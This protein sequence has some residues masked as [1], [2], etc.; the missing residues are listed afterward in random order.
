LNSSSFNSTVYN[1]KKLYDY[2]L[3][4][5]ALLMP[6]VVKGFP[7]LIILAA[8]IGIAYFFRA[9]QKLGKPKKDYYILP[10]NLLKDA[11]TN[12]FRTK[13]AL[14]FMVILFFVYVASAFF[15][16][17][18]EV[19]FQKIILKSCYLYFPLIFSLT[20]WDKRKLLLV[21]DFFVLG[22]CLQVI[23]S[24]LDAFWESGFKF[25]SFE[26]T[27]VNLS[28]NLHP[29]Y[30]AFLVNIGFIFNSIRIIFLYKERKSLS[31]NR[32]RLIALVGF[33]GYIM[34][35][36]SKAG[37]LT[38]L[39]TTITLIIYS[40]IVIKSSKFT[41]LVIL[42]SIGVFSLLS[43]TF[44]SMAL[45]RY[46]TM[47]NSIEKKQEVRN[48][49]KRIGSSQI[50]LVL[51]E[52][53]WEAIKQSTY[54]GYG[55]GNGKNALQETLKMNNEKFVFG[56]NHNS[57][58]QFFEIMLSIGFVGLLLMILIL[59]R[60]SL[61]FGSFTAISILLTFTIVVNFAVE[62]MMERQTGSI[63][64]VWLLCLLTSGR[65]I[66]KTVFKF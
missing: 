29:G 9:Y 19:A 2:A 37:V 11:F 26:F 1:T 36:S 27:Y 54:L 39:V 30:A 48:K 64:I 7:V 49:S 51:W 56:L 35:L 6:L 3:A 31:G 63:P 60:S 50:R 20:K 34:L 23:V 14:L 12:I 28:F 58:N 17:N 40:L 53:S 45:T 33:L 47:K 44:G 38:I 8:T 22:C 66:F 55:L 46:N 59:I 24:L 4:F 5:M 61:G 13:G 43:Y 16:D 65:S 62:S 21:I 42:L 57:H 41:V 18:K 52:N 32:W 25:D 10:Y 15:S